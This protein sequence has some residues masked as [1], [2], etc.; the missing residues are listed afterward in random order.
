M[1]ATRSL[2][3]LGTLAMLSA[4]PAMAQQNA[5]ART[6][7]PAAPAAKADSTVPAKVTASMLVP[8]IEIQ[9]L[10]PADQ[11]GINVFEAPKATDVPFT[12]FKLNWGAAFTQQFQALD[13]EN[14]AAPRLVG[15]PAV[16]RN[17]LTEIGNGFNTATANLNLN[18]QLAPGIRVALT[19]YLSS[20]HHNE[21]WVKDGYL[22]VD[23]APFDFAPLARVMEYVTVKAGHYEI[24]YGDAHFRRT[25]NGNAMYN[26]FVG[27]LILDA[28]TT[29]IGGEV[30]VRAR[31][32]MAMGAISGGE[33]KGDVSAPSRRSPAFYG[34]A[35]LDRQLSPRLRV[36]LTGS[37][38]GQAKAA[39]QTLYSGDR[40]GSR[41]YSVVDTVGATLNGAFTSGSLNPGFNKVRAY[42]VNPFVKYRGLELFGTLET[43]KGRMPTETADRTWT[44]LAGEALVRFAPREQLY[45]GARYN[46]VE[47][48]LR[49]LAQDVGSDRAQLGAGWF[50]TPIVLLKGE[51]VT[52]KYSDFPA[53]DWRNGGKFNGFVV[54][55][56]VAF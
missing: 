54:E 32:L 29:Q 22:L 30:Y 18:A 13:H 9:H 31:G 17:R 2:L 14:T 52:Q 28:F 39:S 21:T 47:G 37:A 41:Y 4:V 43:A 35:G 23:A 34:K 49:G 25:D 51:Y 15:T 40:A 20:R 11:R 3:A 26:P 16:D 19:S 27:N 6:P 45:V 12:G 7:D 1:S 53:A 48:R 10:R 33:I 36:R 44:Q 56:V 46:T 38:Y 24:N 50:I 42:M 55:G 8:A 5:P